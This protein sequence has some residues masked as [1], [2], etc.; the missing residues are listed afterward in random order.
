MT[1]VLC[2][3][4]NGRIP[5]DE[6][7]KHMR[8]KHATPT[9][10]DMCKAKEN[11]NLFY[12]MYQQ[13]RSV[14]APAAPQPPSMSSPSDTT[15]HGSGDGSGKMTTTFSEWQAQNKFAL[16]QSAGWIT[17]ED[18]SSFRVDR[19]DAPQTA[20]WS[21]QKSTK[22][23]I[24]EFVNEF[25]QLGSENREQCNDLIRKMPVFAVSVMSRILAG[26][27][28]HLV[29]WR[30]YLHTFETMRGRPAEVRIKIE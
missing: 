25:Q 26:S 24:Q 6:Y 19:S 12:A 13:R 7:N 18:V 23:D 28:V 16:T 29:P 15:L 11:Y 14:A 8:E 4:C 22:Y 10:Q 20:A 21:L 9:V 30:L 17:S 3:Y 1:N 5:Q 27:H 2:Y